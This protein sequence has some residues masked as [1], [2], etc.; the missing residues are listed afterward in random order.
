MNLFQRAEQSALYFTSVEDIQA[1]KVARFN[2]LSLKSH[3]KSGI[4]NWELG[5]G[6]EGV[7][8]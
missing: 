7:S 3:W 8:L 1:W 2:L 5:I 4:G 6:E